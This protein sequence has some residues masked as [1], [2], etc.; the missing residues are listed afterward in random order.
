MAAFEIF[1]VLLAGSLTLVYG[2]AA[3]VLVRFLAIRHV[4]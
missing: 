2:I 1:G 4:P 3:A